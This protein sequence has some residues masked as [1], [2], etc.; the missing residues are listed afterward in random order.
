MC[1]EQGAWQNETP[2]AQCRSPSVILQH[3]GRAATSTRSEL[4]S[5]RWK[6]LGSKVGWQEL[7]SNVGRRELGGYR[8]AGNKASRLAFQL[9]RKLPFSPGNQ[10][11]RGGLLGSVASRLCGLL[12]GAAGAP[13]Q[14]GS[15]G[16]ARWACKDW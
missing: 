11:I 7:G 13:H 15:L 3:T 1:S 6:S 12:S 2:T 16:A 4:G 5:A 14:L 10:L 8:P 9:S